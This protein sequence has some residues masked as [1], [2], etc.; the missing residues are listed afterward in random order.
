[1]R[2]LVTGA[3]GFVGRYL[4]A[5]LAG[6]GDEVLATDH[7]IPDST[8]LTPGVSWQTLDVSNSTQCTDIISRYEPEAIYHLAGIAFVPEA[9]NNFDRALVVNVGGTNNIIRAVHLMHLGSRVVLIS[10]AEVYGRIEATDLPITENTQLR[11][12]NNYSLSKSMAELVAARYGQFG[13]VQPVIMRPF[14]HV[15]PGQD[16]RFVVSSFAHQLAAIKAGKAEPVIRVGNLDARRDFSD[17]RDIVRAYR[18][19]ALR[20]RGTFNLCSGEPVAIQKILDTLVEIA[21]VD[22]QIERDP[23]RMRP[24][25]VPVLFGSFEKAEQELGWRPEFGL[26]DTL[27]AVFA[28]CLKRAQG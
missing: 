14:N 16:S 6:A 7:R 24:S 20:G 2:V 26:R 28:D 15:G 5:H 12:A 10:S 18:L 23:A 1:M 22:V 19:A 9:E 25:E 27:E 11:P 3:G 13:F 21:G 4:V 17:V 8:P